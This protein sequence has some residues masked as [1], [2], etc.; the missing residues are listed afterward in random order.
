[1][2]LEAVGTSSGRTNAPLA[3][4]PISVAVAPAGLGKPAGRASQMRPHSTV[5]CVGVPDDDE[6]GVVDGGSLDGEYVA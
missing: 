4:S 2:T 6:V 1:M 3:G 5:D